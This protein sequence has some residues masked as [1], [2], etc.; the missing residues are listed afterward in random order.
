M[1]P[2]L[3]LGGVRRRVFYYDPPRIRTWNLLIKSQLLCQ[4][5]LAGLVLCILYSRFHSLSTSP[6]TCRPLSPDTTRH[7]HRQPRPVRGRSSCLPLSTRARIT[8]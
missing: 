8:A 4:I 3:T 1:L 7:T 5:E 2:T 6:P